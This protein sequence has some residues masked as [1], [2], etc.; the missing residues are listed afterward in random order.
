MAKSTLSQA[1][2]RRRA[3]S[4]YARRRYLTFALLVGSAVMLRLLTSVYPVAYAAWLSLFDINLVSQTEVFTGLN[5]YIKMTGDFQVRAS[6]EFTI[7]FVL[8]STI[9]E[10]IVGLVIAQILNASFR[11]QALARTINLIPWAIPT[12]VAAYAF[13]WMLDDQFGM[14][15]DWIV[16]LTGNRPAPLVDPTWARIAL[17]LTNVWKNA[18]FMAVV[19]LA[20]LQGI[21][22]ELYEAA[23]VDGATAWQNFRHITIPLISPLLTTVGMFFIIWQLASFDLIYGMT[24]GGPGVA[25]LV[26]AFRILQEGFLWLKHGFASALSMVLFGLVTLVGLVGLYYFRRQEITF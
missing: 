25:T 8:G 20:G 10:L 13:R 1:K 19:F 11:G 23:R 14:I 22:E 16:R 9:L 17:I 21:P 4:P 7:Y 5:N 12:I 3:L 6:I 24:Q 18:P 2:G 26:I 15:I